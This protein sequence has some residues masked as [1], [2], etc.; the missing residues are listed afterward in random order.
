MTGLVRTARNLARLFAIA[1]ILAR[2]D[3]LFPLRLAGVARPLLWAAG[4]A[5]LLPPSLRR[6]AGGTPGERLQR[7]LQAL[8]PGFVKAGQL[9]SVRGD[10]IGEEMARALS[11]LQDRLPPFPAQRA[12]ATVERELGAPVARLFERFDDR[13]VAAASVAQVHRARTADGREVAVKVLRPGIAAAIARDLELARW[14]ARLMERARPRLGRLR[15]VEVVRSLVEWFDVELDLRLEAAAAAELGENMADDPGFRVPAV[16]W[17]RTSQSVL[18]LEWVEGIPVD[19]AEALA[20]QGHDPEKLVAQAARAFFNQVFRDGFFHADMHPGNLFVDCAGAIVAVDFGIMGR[21]D[22]PT[23]LALAGMLLGLLSRDWRRVADLHF[24]VGWVPADRS[25]DLFAQACRSI[26]EPIL[27]RPQGEISMA[28]LLAQL[29]R[30]TERFG[31]A[32]QPRLLLLQK[33]MLVTEGIARRL[34]P[35]VDMWALIRPPVEDWAEANL[36]PPARAAEAARAGGRVLARLPELAG[37]VEGMIDEA[38]GEGLR[39]HRDTVADLARRSR[40]G[41]GRRRAWLWAA[42]VLALLAA[43]LMA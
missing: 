38:A 2:H 36:S 30:V 23:R 40:A 10:L 14:L 17:R 25:R 33:T 21:L 34:A 6:P 5:A 16:D 24:E 15:P 7:A 41:R 35:G 4:L 13:P 39:L 1:R 29:F 31:M 22:R 32:T 26:G 8:G 42:S 18:T 11:G 3:A 27:G 43:A 19:E 9:F 20:A 37:K 12:R 28:R